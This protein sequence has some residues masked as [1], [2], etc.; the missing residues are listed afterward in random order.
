MANPANLDPNLYN[1]PLLKP[2][3]LGSLKLSSGEEFTVL[4]GHKLFSL[5]PR[6]TFYN[7][8][9][10]V[11]CDHFSIIFG[12]GNILSYTNIITTIANNFK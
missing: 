7:G 5:D 8:H 11:P 4:K 3:T 6:Y 9:S 1:F 2:N 10:I 12:N